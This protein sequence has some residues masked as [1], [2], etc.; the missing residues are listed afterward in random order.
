MSTFI[1]RKVEINMTVVGLPQPYRI[2]VNKQDADKTIAETWFVH[3]SN[4]ENVVL[5]CKRIESNGAE[6]FIPLQ[7]LILDAPADRY[8]SKLGA[9]NDYRKSRLTLTR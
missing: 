1:D 5:Y 6:I 3:G 2:I 9:Y 7:N 8:V 4:L